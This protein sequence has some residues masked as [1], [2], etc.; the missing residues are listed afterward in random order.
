[1]TNSLFSLVKRH[2]VITFFLATFF[3]FVLLVIYLIR[4]AG[5]MGGHVRIP[6]GRNVAVVELKGALLSSKEIVD[7][8]HS[9]GENDH[10]KGVVLLINSPGGGVAPSQEIY[11]EIRKLGKKKPVVASM[12]SVAASGGYYVASAADKIVANPG[13]L[14]GSI[15]VIME[16]SNVEGLL[17]KL[18]LKSFV[19]KSGKYKDV[20]SPNRPMTEKEREYIQQL[21]DSVHKQFVSAVAEGRGMDIEAVNIISDGR[22]LTGEQALELGLID[23]LG[24]LYDAISLV[25]KMA[26]IEGDAKPFYMEKEKG[27]AD[28]LFGRSFLDILGEMTVPQLQYRADFL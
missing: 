23:E 4:S 22:I 28:Y 9:A 27:V 15:G 21:I 8:I 26:A 3:C 10:I 11:S 19:V 14:T 16:F 13:T 1:M 5:D 24:N 2:P 17:H 18:G 7:Q 6:L 25:A 20:G 12:S